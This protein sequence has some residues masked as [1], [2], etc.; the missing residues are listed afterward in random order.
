[1]A[2]QLRRGTDAERQGITPKEGELIYVTDTNRLWIGGKIAP[3]Q[4]LE[5]GGIL[6]SG[7]LVNDTNPTLAEDLDLNG[8]NITGNGNISI[9]GTI[10]ATG[11]VNLGDGVEDNVVVGGQIGSSLIPGTDRSFD[12]GASAS[13]WKTIYTSNIDVETSITTGDVLLKGNIAKDDS[14][15]IYDGATG[16]LSVGAITASSLEAAAITGNLTGSVFG[17]DS[18]PMVDGVSKVLSN[19]NVSIN[20]DRIIGS[21]LGPNYES[22]FIAA[23]P[24]VVV[25]SRADTNTLVIEGSD[26]PLVLRGEASNTGSTTISVQGSR[27][28]GETKESVQQNDFVGQIAFDGYNGSDFKRAA[29]MHTSVES[30]LNAGNFD[31]NLTVSVLQS[32]GLYSQ[33]VFE[34]DGRFNCVANSYTPLPDA[35]LPALATYVPAGSVGYGAERDSLVMFDGTSFK[36]IPTFV[37]VPSGPSATGIAGQV[38]ADTDY[39]YICHSTDN[40]IR[41]AKDATW[42]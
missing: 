1:M 31:T 13:A 7:S 41:V 36:T 12:L 8:N 19:G 9:N 18:T 29:L 4:S 30:A 32:S 6:V 33:F 17:D 20:G 35:V 39:M 27:F 40:W 2:L 15:I 38:S 5:Q 21:T 25:G 42:T 23:D 11:T 26:I 3:N 24:V 22:L 14:T 37:S 28:T 10:T 34:Y 16:S